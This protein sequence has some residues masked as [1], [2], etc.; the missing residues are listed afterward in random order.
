MS[1]RSVLSSRTLL[2]RSIGVQALVIAMAG[3]LIAPAAATTAALA[4]ASAAVPRYDHV[5]MVILENHSQDG[6][7]ANTAAPYINSL[8]ANGA[9]MTQSYA[10][11]H[12]SQPNYLALFSG[13]VQGVLDDACPETPFTADNLGAQLISAGN[14]FVGYSETMPSAG[15][16]GCQSGTYVRKH[17]P[18]V[19][20]AN[21]PASSNQPL[22]A[23]PS[24][25][26][27]LPTV[28]IVVPN[29]QND[30]HDGSVGQADSWVRDRFDGYVTWAKQHNSL[31][32]LTFDE[33]DNRAGNRIPTIITGA[34]VRTGRYPERVSHYNMLRTL[35]DMYGLPPLGASATAGAIV[36]IWDSSPVNQTPLA[37][38]TGTCTQLVCAVD[39]TASSDPGGSLAGYTWDWG[40]GATSSGATASHTFGSPGAK[41]VTLMVTDNLGGTATTSNQLTVSGP[42]SS[43]PIAV[44]N[45]ARTRATGW[46]SADVG[47]GWS[48]GSAA[49]SSVGAGV[50]NLVVGAGQ[51]N[52]AMLPGVGSTDSDLQTTFSTDKVPNGSGI[53]LDLIGRR[54]G[55]NLQY[56]A[57]LMVRSDGQVGV[58]LTALNGT[59]SLVTLKPQIIAPGVSTANSGQVK[60][61]LQVTGTSP[62]SVRAKVWPAAGTEPAAWQLNTTDSFAGLQSAGYVGISPYLSSSATNGPVTLRLSGFSVRPTNQPPTAAFTGTCTQLTCAVDG[63]TST[64]VDGTISSYAWNWGDG[65]TT[66]GASS[67]HTFAKAGPATVTLTVTD[68]RGGVATVTHTLTPTPPANLPPTA[69]FTVHCT[70][71][72]CDADSATSSDPDGTLAGFSWDWGD[73]SSGTGATAH[74]VYAAAG[75]ATIRL[76]VTD[77][78]GA[79]ATTTQHVTVAAPPTQA[80][81]ALFTSN[82]ALLTCSVDGGGSSDPDGTIAGYSWS[83]GDGGTSSGST[84]THTYVSPGPYTV[85][86]TVTDNGGATG[87]STRDV[88]AILPANRAPTAIAAGSCASLTCSVDA[89]GSADPDGSITGYSWNWGDGTSSSGPTGSHVYS[90][91]GAR[92]VTLTVTDNQGSSGTAMVALNP[93][94]PASGDPFARDAFARTLP[95]G[96]GTADTGGS[97]TLSGAASKYAVGAAAG[98]MIVK[99]GETDSAVLQSVSSTRH[100]SA[101]HIFGGQAGHR[102]RHLDHADRP[103]GRCQSGIS[104]ATARPAEWLG[105]PDPELSEWLNHRGDPQTGGPAERAHPRRRRRRDCAAAGHRNG[106]DHGAGQGLEGGDRRTHDVA[107]HCHRFRGGVAIPRVGG[108]DRVRVQRIDGIAGHSAAFG[109]LGPTGR[110]ALTLTRSRAKLWRWCRPA[111]W[112]VLG[113][114]SASTPLIGR[115]QELAAARRLHAAA[116]NGAGGLLV[117]TGEA[118]I[119]K[120]RLLAELAGTARETGSTVLL[121]RSFPGGGT[122]RAL[123]A[124]VAAPLR[125][126]SSAE[127]DRLRPFRAPFARLAPAWAD[128][129]PSSAGDGAPDPIVMLGEGLLQLLSGPEQAAGSVL[130]LEDVHWADADTLAVLAYLA[131]AAQGSPVLV[132]VSAR[133][134]QSAPVAASASG[135]VT[136]ADLVSMSGVT[137]LRLGR[138][139]DPVV[140]AIAAASAG[141]APVDEVV[142]AAL[143]DKADGLPVL[144]DELLTALLD[145]AR[146]GGAGDQSV[147][148]PGAFQG[149]VQGRVSALDDNSRTV[150]QAAAVL[151]PEPNWSL[152]PG[153]HPAAKRLCTPPCARPQVPVCLSRRVI[154]CAG[155]TR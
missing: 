56:G 76:T 24:D 55:I 1:S 75:D 22:T 63:V 71:L 51:T 91:A 88:V 147:P 99:A 14:T 50:G 60:V 58:W 2:R 25:F 84:S 105:R 115:D 154:S 140:A 121:G 13:S 102:Q 43:Q 126:L 41:T 21:V 141:D 12:P 129:T 116:R 8:A 150:A 86:L 136:V 66:G 114:V 39:A 90:S 146:L 81:I 92:A 10:V 54:T 132:A 118:G 130:I 11:T 64:D 23:L 148:V 96:W 26:T 87:S 143:V 53:Y 40:D 48:V 34:G 145:R 57:R 52:A 138:L 100:R 78:A 5:V 6:I 70:M 29:L 80:P 155:V 61:R 122:Y 149:L 33:D 9:L 65:T 153:G 77:N 120:T 97:W 128:E 104:R 79:T 111:W 85:T 72:N 133:D 131:G 67:T 109:L 16:T 45:F 103:P 17:N 123:A 42:P 139:G 47:G 110:R 73:G 19:D 144:I 38:F 113:A 151:G 49:N 15:F 27:T 152:L 134:D 59:T 98:T 124:A 4:A 31:F 127:T 82:C 108:G 69:A 74:H 32:I 89:A 106:T 95:S 93:T 7:V 3:T 112:V 137:T 68:D 94:A 30:M 142:L 18:W 35:Q 28:S 83:W 107:A 37:A 119:G 36:D 135:V 44:D 46:G 117:V 20:F 125:A 101:V 62:T